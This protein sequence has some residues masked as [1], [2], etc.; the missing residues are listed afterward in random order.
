MNKQEIVEKI[1]SNGAVAV[2]RMEDPNK[3]IKVVDAL[4][5]GGVSSIEITMTVPNAISMIEKVCKEFGSSVLV[6]VGS[7]LN[8]EMAQNAI[9]AGAQYVVSPILKEEI[10]KKAQKNNKAVMPGCF[11]PT[12][13][14]LAY[15]LGADIIKVFPADVL[16]IE[17]FKGVKAP[18]PH[19]KLMP[20]GGVTLT[21]ACEW[22]SA[23]ACAVGVGSV[24]LDKK[25]IAEGNYSLLKSNA[26]ILMNSIK[27]YYENIKN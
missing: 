10:I 17:F 6:G 5:S 20:T 3:L 25:A 7:V 12:E 11:T 19:L 21:N 14:N 13:I 27:N 24:L 22:L 9:D 16:G 1:I 18:M 23:G 26:E 4:Q 15:E 2:V 8:A